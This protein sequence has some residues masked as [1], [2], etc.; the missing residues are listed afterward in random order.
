M[1]DNEV[2]NLDLDEELLNHLAI[3]ESWITLQGEDFD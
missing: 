3:E 2:F 1:S